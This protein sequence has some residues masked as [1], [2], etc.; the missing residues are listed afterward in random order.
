M[1][2]PTNCKNIFTL[3]QKLHL[4][5]NIVGDMFRSTC[6]LLPPVLPLPISHINRLPHIK[7]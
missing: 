1:P 2:L 5:L 6:W 7:Y 3:F 4:P